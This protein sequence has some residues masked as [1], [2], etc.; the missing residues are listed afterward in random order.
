MI[1][2]S[3]DGLT[4]EQTAVSDSNTIQING[5]EANKQYFIKV[6]AENS[7][8]ISRESEV[9]SVVTSESTEPKILIV[10]GFD[11]TSDGNTFNF[12]RQHGESVWN[13]SYF[14]ESATND[15]IL[16]GLI[17]LQNYPYRRLYY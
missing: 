2:L 14:Y 4:F 9:L 6:A 12:I 13:N 10:N 1:Y 5:L 16:D 3:E 11:R 7:F 15:A 17:N 8:G